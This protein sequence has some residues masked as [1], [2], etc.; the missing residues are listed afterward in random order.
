MFALLSRLEVAVTVGVLAAV[1]LVLVAKWF[2]AR[3]ELLVYGVGLGFTALA[4][5]LFALQRGAP[6]DHLGRELVGAV[7]YLTIAVLG[8]RRRPALLALGW[9]AHAEWDLFF[10]YANG[11]AFA[12]AWYALFCV[13]FDL[14]VG[15]YIAGLAAA[16]LPAA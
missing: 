10:H 8:T 9:I 6:A 16:R 13:G 5:V 11:P 12:P 4:Y 15:G 7:L 1:G 14:V 2:A 3:R